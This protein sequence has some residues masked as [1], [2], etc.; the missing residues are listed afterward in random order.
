MIVNFHK[1]FRKSYK[2][3]NLKTQRRVDLAIHKF[4]ANPFD[5]SLRNHALKGDLAKRRALSVTGDLRV[6]F[7]EHGGY[8][9]VVMLDVGSHAQ[10]YR[11]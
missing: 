3:L 1:N 5:K 7:E 6:V 4:R 8:V 10:V 9:L 11:S 2:R